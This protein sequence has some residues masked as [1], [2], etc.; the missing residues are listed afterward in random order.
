M[1]YEVES[2]PSPV[3]KLKVKI[4]QVDKDEDGDKMAGQWDS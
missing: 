2:L 1:F 3:I 4:S